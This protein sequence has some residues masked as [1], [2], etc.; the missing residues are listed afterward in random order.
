METQLPVSVDTLFQFFLKKVE[1]R[2]VCT[3][4]K[5]K[6]KTKIGKL[7]K[8]IWKKTVKYDKI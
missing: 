5:L 4:K 3:G 2:T 7:K 1:I 8:Y 6:E